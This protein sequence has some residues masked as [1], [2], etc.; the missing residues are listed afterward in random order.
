LFV[1]FGSVVEVEVL[2]CFEGSLQKPAPLLARLIH[3][4]QQRIHEIQVVV[5]RAQVRNFSMA[6][7]TLHVLRSRRISCDGTENSDTSPK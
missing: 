2:D 7:W 5:W 3:E 6:K 1:I 4:S